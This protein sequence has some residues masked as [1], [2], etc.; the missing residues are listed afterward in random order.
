MGSM[1]QPLFPDY[2]QITARPK[3]RLIRIL[4]VHGQS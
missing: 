2:R 4:K 1:S 3:F